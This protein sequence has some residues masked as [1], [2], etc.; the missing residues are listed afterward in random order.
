MTPM[1]PQAPYLNLTGRG[2]TFLVDGKGSIENAS[3]G[4][5]TGSSIPVP[6]PDSIGQK[7]TGPREGVRGVGDNQIN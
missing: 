2:E 7:V 3:G 4:G 6:E 5:R 1:G